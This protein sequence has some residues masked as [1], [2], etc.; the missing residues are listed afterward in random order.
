MKDDFHY[1]FEGFGDF[2]RF[3]IF[4]VF[5]IF[6]VVFTEAFERSKSLIKAFTG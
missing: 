4:S 2:L 3:S 5:G 6:V 1:D